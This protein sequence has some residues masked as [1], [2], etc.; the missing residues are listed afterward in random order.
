MAEASM[1]SQG[2]LV[3]VGPHADDLCTVESLSNGDS[4]WDISANR[5]V[6]LIS[7][8][9][10]TLDGASLRQLGFLALEVPASRGSGW[11]ALSSTRLASAP[12]HTDPDFGATAFFRL[13]PE[14]RL[15]AEVGGQA[16][17]IRGNLA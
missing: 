5:L 13:W 17:L 1:L 15:V 6:D 14:T 2:L 16:I 4:L 3:R 8:S 10:M 7:M 12:R 11:L 9:C